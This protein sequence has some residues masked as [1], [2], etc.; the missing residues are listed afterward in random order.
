MKTFITLLLLLT[1]CHFL[2]AQTIDGTAAARYF[3]LTDT[4]RQGRAV[5]YDL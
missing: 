5:S 3:E 1:S 2:R 4:L